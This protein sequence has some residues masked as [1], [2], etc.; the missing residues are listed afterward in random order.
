[1]NRSE[2]TQ[3]VRAR[4]LELGFDAVGFS[5]AV[6]LDREARRLGEWLNKGYHGTMHWMENHFEKRIDPR[7]LVP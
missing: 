2:I 6:Q 1:M 7:K 3:K 4:A 5:R